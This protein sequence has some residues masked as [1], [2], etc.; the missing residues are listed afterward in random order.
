MKRIP[1]YWI[2]ATVILAGLLAFFLYYPILFIL[3]KA[4]FPVKGFSLEFFVILFKNDVMTQA[5]ITSFTMGIIVTLGCLIV[6]LPLA[7]FSTRYRLKGQWLL[8]SLMML[9]MVL[10]P[11]VGAIGMKQFLARFGTFNIILMNTGVID[12]PIDWLGSG[13][14]GVVILEVLHL[15]PIV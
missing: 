8:N 11:F 9:P 14:W 2:A 3:Q 15:F 7:W 4:F 1:A 13:F 5:V 12:K 10:P 6:A